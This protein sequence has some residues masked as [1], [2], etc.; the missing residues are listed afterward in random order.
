MK[1]G[2]W[3]CFGLIAYTYLIYPILIHFLARFFPRKFIDGPFQYPFVSM[4]IPA[5]NEEKVLKDKIN[6]CLAID[7]PEE[8]I[9]FLFGSDGSSDGTNQIL[10]FINHPQIRTFLFPEQEGKSSVLNKLIPEAN[11][12]IILF[13]DAN[14]MY[15]TDVVKPIYHFRIQQCGHMNTAVL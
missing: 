6:S 14:S 3:I 10:Q 1:Y 15:Q 7:Y 12:S 8:K 2:F 13:S 11:G 4:V 9:E 5:Y